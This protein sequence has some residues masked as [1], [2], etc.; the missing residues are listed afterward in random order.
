MHAAVVEAKAA[1]TAML[2]A[3]NQAGDIHQASEDVLLRH[4]Y[5]VS[6]GTLTDHVSIQ[7]GTGHGI[8]LD[9]HEPILLDSGGAEVLA[10]EVF[11]VEPGLY[12]RHDGGVRVED[13]LLVTDGEARNLNRL[14]D[15]L[16]WHR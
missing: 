12:G 11:T 10:G 15:G 7:H 5:P 1:A 2:R 6:R 3:G 9:L 14:H 4:G 8:G 16:D 13:M